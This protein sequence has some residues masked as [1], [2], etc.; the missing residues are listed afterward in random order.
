ME[1]ARLAGTCP[2][3]NTCPTISKTDRGTIVVQGLMLSA[4]DLSEIV[5]PDGETVVE[6]PAELLQEAARA[7]SA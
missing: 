1:L 2:D 7:Y 3:G 5:L 6:I 4:D